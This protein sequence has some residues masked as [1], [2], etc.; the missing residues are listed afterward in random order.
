MVSSLFRHIWSTNVLTPP[1]TL[2][3]FQV[4]VPGFVRHRPAGP[5][6]PRTAEDAQQSDRFAPLATL[7]LA[8]HP[9]R[10]RRWWMSKRSRPHQRM[11]RSE[12]DEPR[13]PQKTIGHL[14]NELD[15]SCTVL[16]LFQQLTLSS[17]HIAMG[18]QDFPLRVAIPIFG[19]LARRSQNTPISVSKF[20]ALL[21][22]F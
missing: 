8:D 2:E 10:R 7:A 14:K 16:N 15:P 12:K 11:Q 21:S 6:R 13:P 1:K 19:S 5:A 20:L 17:R 9:G 4:G 3:V 22:F 18:S